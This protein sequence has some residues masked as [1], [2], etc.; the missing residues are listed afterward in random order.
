MGYV[1]SI[2]KNT[3]FEWCASLS[4]VIK[5]ASNLAKNEEKPCSTCVQPIS[6]GYFKCPKPGFRDAGF[7]Y[8][9]RYYLLTI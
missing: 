9:F 3:D 5:Y 6:P 7:G 8:P 4:K 2:E 1:T